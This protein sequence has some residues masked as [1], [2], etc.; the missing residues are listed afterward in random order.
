M[1]DM[2]SPSRRT[3]EEIPGRVL[4]FLMAVSKSPPIRAAL[5]QRGYTEEE[6]QLGWSLLATLA[7]YSPTTQAPNFDVAV[8]DALAELEPWDDLNFPAIL[9]ILERLHPA[10]AKFVFENLEPKQGSESVLAITR[11]LDRLDALENDPARKATRKAD[12]AA[13]ATLAK[14]GYPK[15]ERERL[16]GLIKTT[17]TAAITAPPDETNRLDVLRELY[18]WHNDWSTQAKIAIRRRDHLILLGLAQRKKGK[19]R[20]KGDEPAAPEPAAPPKDALPGAGGG[21]PSP[22]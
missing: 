4:S 6:H 11:L 17:Q 10:Q 3:L 13:L 20:G 9:A 22:S 2:D 19:Q 12:Q 15:E 1:T 18:G 7:K 8:R 5:A 14:R 16:R 21:T